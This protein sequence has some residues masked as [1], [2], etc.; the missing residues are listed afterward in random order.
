MVPS[1]KAVSNVI[2]FTNR[3]MIRDGI[4]RMVKSDP[5]LLFRSVPL[6]IKSIET[7]AAQMTGSTVAIVDLQHV[8]RPLAFHVC[9]AIRQ[10]HP[11]VRLVGFA[12]CPGDLS[13][14]DLVAL[15]EAGVITVLD[16][17]MR[18]SELL[19]ALREAAPRHVP[20]A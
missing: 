10:R 20:A 11:E 7:A 8:T 12:C 15:V 1:D 3:S 14:Q 17:Y 6:K 4:A 9:E 13:S 19:H 16:E 5:D 18:K 2:L